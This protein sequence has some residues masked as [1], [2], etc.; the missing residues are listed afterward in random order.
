MNRTCRKQKPSASQKLYF[1]FLVY[2]LEPPDLGAV[3]PIIEIKSF[4]HTADKGSV[5]RKRAS[6]DLSGKAAYPGTHPQ[7]SKG[8]QEIRPQQ[9]CGW[10]STGNF[11]ALCAR[12][13]LGSQQPPV[14]C[15]TGTLVP[16]WGH[17]HHQ[18][19]MSG[20]TNH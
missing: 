9:S 4:S 14:H 1:Q 2:S 11:R 8:N 7:P 17:F 16:L 20:C 12:D 19:M 15:V 18:T 3:I 13:A 5:W 6:R 10:G